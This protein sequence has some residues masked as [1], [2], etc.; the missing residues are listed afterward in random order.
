MKASAGVGLVILS[1]VGDILL[2][3]QVRWAHR[4]L[5]QLIHD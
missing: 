1:Q 2:W 5:E 4:L 3:V